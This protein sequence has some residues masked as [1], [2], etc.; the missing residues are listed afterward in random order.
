MRALCLAI[1]LCA[2]L[3]AAA[4]EWMMITLPESPVEP[5]PQSEQPA[6]SIRVQPEII[7]H[8][9]IAS[10]DERYP[11]ICRIKTWDADGKMSLGSGTFIGTQG[12][13]GYVITVRHL[14]DKQPR[15]IKCYFPGHGLFN[16]AVAH[17][18]GHEDVAVLRILDP[19]I[20]PMKVAKEP[21]RVGDSLWGAGYGGDGRLEWTYGRVDY[22]YFDTSTG[23]RELSVVGDI[24]RF[25][26][27]GGPI[28]NSR[29]ELAGVQWGHSRDTWNVVGVQ[30]G[31]IWRLLGW[32][33]DAEV[34]VRG[35]RRPHQR[36][37]PASRG[38]AAQFTRP[39]AQLQ[40]INVCPQGN[41]RPYAV[42]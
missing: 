33:P 9:L 26:D 35:D 15:A 32:D 19:G 7:P 5:A 37:Q 22:R 2:A 20:E 42:H 1:A 34:Y 28:I 29:G 39:P 41:C 25:G 13:A 8:D 38:N 36:M 6:T 17:V 24:N 27:S 4:G 31:V 21:P 10:Y 3:P 23:I 11:A 40:P 18:D 12:P 14:L 16:A 30:L